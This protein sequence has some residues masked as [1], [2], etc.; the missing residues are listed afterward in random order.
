[1]RVSALCDA[2]LVI[3]TAPER[4]RSA[5]LR[6]PRGI[7]A[8]PSPPWLSLRQAGSASLPHCSGAFGLGSLAAAG[9]VGCGRRWQARSLPARGRAALLCPPTQQR[10]CLPR[11]NNEPKRRARPSR[12]GLVRQ[13]PAAAAERC[14]PCLA[15]AVP[16]GAD[17]GERQSGKPGRGRGDHREEQE[18][19]H[20]HIGGP[21][22]KKVRWRGSPTSHRCRSW[23]RGRSAVAPAAVALGRITGTGAGAQRSGRPGATGMSWCRSCAKT[24][25]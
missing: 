14:R 12:E 7:M 22:L 19:D 11:S 9:W 21:I 4:V 10:I 2:P 23:P 16:A 25:G 13:E 15:G 8:Q 17:Q 6:W 3:Q 20:R 5:G 24:L 18:Q 1:M